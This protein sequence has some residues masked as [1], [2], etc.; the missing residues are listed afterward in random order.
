[1]QRSLF[2]RTLPALL[3]LAAAP[4]GA[5]SVDPARTPASASEEDKP[6]V[7]SEF[8]VTTTQDRG[9]RATNTISGTRL[10]TPIRD[11][12]IPI[13]V[14]TEEFIRD[15]GAANLRESLRYSAGLFTESQS[16]AFS[17]LSVQLSDKEETVI[18]VRGFVTS[19]ALRNGFRRAHTTDAVNIARVEVVRGP[20][21]LLYGVG[22][23]GG[24]VN[25]IA[26]TPAARPGYE[27]AASFGSNDYY[28]AEL[29]FTGPLGERWG[30]GY[31]LTA[32]WLDQA[33]W[34]EFNTRKQK[35]VSPVFEF[36]P[37]AST[38]VLL[39]LE[40]GT[41]RRDGIAFQR[42][43]NT[44]NQ[45]VAQQRVEDWL[46]S[47]NP[48]TFRWSGPDT[49]QD[50]K[51]GNFLAQVE[52]RLSDYA[53]FVVGYN[54]SR[55]DWDS[56]GFTDLA[57]RNNLGPVALRRPLVTKMGVDSVP[58][59]F[60]GVITR[61]RWQQELDDQTREQVRAELALRFATGGASHRFLVGR[62]DAD[63][64]SRLVLRRSAADLFKAID[65]YTYFRFD[66][67]TQPAMNVLRRERLTFVDQGSY[68]VYQGRYW[69]DRVQTVSGIRYDRSDT[70]REVF[71][72]ATGE[73]T[74][75]FGRVTGKPA[76]KVS[77]QVGVTYRLRHD[78]S[79]Y[80]LYATGLQ[81]NYT[82]QDG[83]GNPFDPTEAESMEVGLKFDFLDGRISGTLSMFSIDRTN[84]TRNV[85]FAPAPVR[86][87][88]NPALP[89]S[90][91][92][93]GVLRFPDNPADVPFIIDAIN[94]GLSYYGA[95]GNN[96][97]R[98]RGALI[99]VDDRSRGL[100]T[101]IV[102]SPTDNFQLVFTYAFID[103]EVTSGGRL[104]D[105][106][107]DTEFDIWYQDYPL[108]R[109]GFGRANFR[110]IGDASS[111]FGSDLV[112]QSL[113]DTPRHNV[114]A[115]GN[116]Q[117]RD[118]MLAGF[119]AALGVV[120]TSPREFQGA[121]LPDGREVPTADY[122][123]KTNVDLALGYRLRWLERD[124]D[125]RLNVYNLMDDQKRYGRVYNDPRSM[126]FTAR[127][128]F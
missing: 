112:G 65:D 41:L 24:I 36:R 15:T 57:L 20:S 6:I 104:V 118:G 72:P 95:P 51:A 35:F 99:A 21:A 120:W 71:S 52:Q 80:G 74:G 17:N 73:L 61:Y 77:P 94:R 1:M 92:I 88:F 26:K 23:F 8:R 105:H 107:Y 56:L 58:T 87:F 45:N 113:D 97:S 43:N 29:D 48:R 102:L 81:P 127:L 125:F 18:K 78:L 103:R 10:D 126:R 19:E 12:P 31:R 22:N 93:D 42:I 64:V 111:Y 116:Y 39:D 67:A 44:L 13:Q 79:V 63:R 75:T 9:Y 14:I 86:G 122:P 89:V 59:L 119:S 109:V 38:L 5:Q 108:G 25:Y 34:T 123:S 33:H 101:Q 106:P 69:G 50:N 98:D 11:V 96:A 30:A 82:Q 66:P 40:L 32:S 91:A 100:D 128:R 3:L 121:I 76:T 28:R 124:W 4:A 62:Q 2:F 83:A 55:S 37:F 47:P 110:Q 7:L 49:Y 114:S 85:W 53:S 115:W 16:D 46:P 90:Y 60:P 117:F 68:L 84:A 70:R 54:R 27:V